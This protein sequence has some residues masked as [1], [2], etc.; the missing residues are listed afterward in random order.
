MRCSSLT[1]TSTRSWKPARSPPF[2]L[3]GWLLVA[4]VVLLVVIVDESDGR[5]KRVL[6]GC[7]GLLSVVMR[8]ITVGSRIDLSTR[9]CLVVIVLQHGSIAV[10]WSSCWVDFLL[11]TLELLARTSDGDELGSRRTLI[12]TGG[13]DADVSGTADIELSVEVFSPLVE[14]IADEGDERF[15]SREKRLEMVNFFGSVP[16]FFRRSGRIRR[17][18]LMNQLQTWLIERSARRERLAFSSSVG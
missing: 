10:D 12:F 15:W 9:W 13:I 17:R 16:S 14:Q 7:C 8:L 3:L 2:V 5:S 11:S 4:V 18:A 6:V 1:A